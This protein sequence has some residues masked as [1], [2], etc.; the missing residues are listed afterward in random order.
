MANVK[1]KFIGLLDMLKFKNL[2]KTR[3]KHI[4][5]GKP[6]DIVGDW[7]INQN[8]RALHPNFINVQVNKIY[9]HKGAN[10]KTY[11][12]SK[13]DN[14]PLPY[15][16]AGQYI[17]IKLKIGKSFVTRAYSISSG[18]KWSQ[19]GKYCITVKENQGG[20][21]AP[22]VL[23]NFKVGTELVISSP[24]GDFYYQKYR[25]NKTIVA[26]AGGSG[27]TPFLSMGFAIKDG[28][29]D[30]NLVIFIGS[31]D[32]KSILFKEELEEITRGT[33][34][35]KVIH[36][37]SNEKKEGYEHGFIT[38]SLIKK[39]VKDPYS[40][41]ICGPKAMYDFLDKELKSLH[42]P[43]RLIRSE[44]FASISD[45]KLIKGYPKKAS[46][47]TF[48]LTIK[49]GPNTYKIK[50]DSNE[51][52]LV[53]IERAGIVAPSRCRSGECGWCRSRVNKGTFFIA[54]ED[55][56]RYADKESNHIHPCI[57]YP[58]SDMVIEV[59]GE[60]IE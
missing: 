18:P 59:P 12:L 1:V 11:I 35:V 13:K 44:K 52:I 56:R 30:F 41:Y 3:D 47:K 46:D 28:I 24:Q 22:Y 6:L 10:A 37:L 16:R 43:R 2:K 34:K 57:T 33:D 51:P 48:N 38:S 20:F 45:V 23:K 5:R 8:A 17:S 42:L 32:E 36:V 31:K 39:Y 60:Y 9:E 25:D 7:K 26:L 15:F 27:L 21:V 40:I 14:S 53:A 49:Q 19:I 50:A 29:E 4:S 55:S 54:G 58:T